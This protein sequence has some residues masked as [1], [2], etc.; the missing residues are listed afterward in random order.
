MINPSCFRLIL[1][2]VC[3]VILLCVATV[4]AQI[5]LAPSQLLKPQP[6]TS[7]QAEDQGGGKGFSEVLPEEGKYTLR[8]PWQAFLMSFVLPGAGE[9]YAGSG[10]KSKIFFGAE[11]GFWSAL[12]SFR[13][14]G[15]WRKD[16]YK[17]YAVDYAGA[18]IN[19]KDDRFFD[20]LGFYSSREDYNKAG[21]V[22]NPG[23]EYYP[24][25]AFYNWSWS[26][27]ATQDRY[28]SLKNDSKSY[29]RKSNFALGLVIANH[30][31][32]AVD[33]YWS[34]KRHNR[35]H[36]AGFSGLDLQMLE[37]GGVALSLSARF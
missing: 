25:T 24:N 22:T 8:R 5:K 29:Y 11:L 16:D 13:Q 27:T 26:S 14:L 20:V 28:R 30:L 7:Y 15:S 35:S 32:S 34:V 10:L 6:V 9:Y 12:V 4:S 3:A 21:S 17:N 37:D 1:V 31:L 23:Q 18:D 33:A 36:E 2:A 19:G